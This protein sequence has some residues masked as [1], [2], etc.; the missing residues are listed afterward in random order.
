MVIVLTDRGERAVDAR[1]DG[2]RLWMD[3]AALEAATGWAL[4]PQGLCR[5]DAC[6]PLPPGRQEDFVQ[7][8]RVDATAV[9]WHLDNPV[10]HDDA[11]EVWVLGEG[12]D[13][14]EAT[15][16]SLIAP[17]FTLPDVNGRPH[18]LSDYRGKK[19]LLVSWASW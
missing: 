16:A 15:L 18:S 17:D 9:W 4:R 10:V 19:I 6:I 5:E 3:G 8:G 14:R 12:A 2:E 7:G 13:E 1:V 11:R